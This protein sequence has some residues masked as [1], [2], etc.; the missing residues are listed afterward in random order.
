VI[1]A[2][3][4]AEAIGAQYGRGLSRQVRRGVPEGLI[5]PSGGPWILSA[6]VGVDLSTIL[7][8]RCDPAD[9]QA[10][11]WSASR[12]ISVIRASASAS[13]LFVGVWSPAAGGPLF[14]TLP[15]P[16]PA[17]GETSD[18]PPAPRALCLIP[19]AALSCRPPIL[20]EETHAGCPLP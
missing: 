3:P 15:H 2:K 8:H 9:P 14:R 17:R 4:S 18:P 13:N 11:A 1:A 12:N 10:L 7:P 16:P 19:V 20:A 6:D 5:H